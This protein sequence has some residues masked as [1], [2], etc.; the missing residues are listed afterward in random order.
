MIT[1]VASNR[2]LNGPIVSFD[3]SIRFGMVFCGQ[4]VVY[5]QDLTNI[6]KELGAEASSVIV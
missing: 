4:G 3:L 1:K 5:D 6:L 2:G